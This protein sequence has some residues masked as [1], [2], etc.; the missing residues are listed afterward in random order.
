MLE[1]ENAVPVFLRVY[2]KYMVCLDCDQVGESDSVREGGT[3]ES[4]VRQVGSPR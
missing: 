4:G 1:A 2:C 3:I